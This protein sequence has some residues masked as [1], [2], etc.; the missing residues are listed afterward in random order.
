M[1]RHRDTLHPEVG[2]ERVTRPVVVEKDDAPPRAQKS[3]V[4]LDVERLLRVQDDDA[5]RRLQRVEV[6][7]GRDDDP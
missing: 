3:R 2:E 4:S 1:L 5:V 6:Q 7:A